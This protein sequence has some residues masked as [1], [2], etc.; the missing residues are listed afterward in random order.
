MSFYSMVR[1]RKFS[2][3]HFEFN[4]SSIKWTHQKLKSVTSVGKNLVYKKFK[5]FTKIGYINSLIFTRDFK[6]IISVGEDCCVKIWDFESK[7]CI[8]TIP[9]ASFSIKSLHLNNPK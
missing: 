6:Q 9:K 4:K 2:K 1:L 3:M 8:H 5:P 7:K